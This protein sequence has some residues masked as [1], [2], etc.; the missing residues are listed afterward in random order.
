[1]STSNVTIQ[2]TYELHYA[3]SATWQSDGTKHW[4]VCSCGAEVDTVPH[5]PDR[6]EATETK[7][8]RRTECGF[9]ITP[10]LGHVTHAPYKEWLFDYVKHWNN[11]T[12]CSQKLDEAEHAFGEWTITVQPQVGVAGEKERKCSV[13]GNK[14]TELVAK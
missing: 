6:A 14:E 11:C 10:A 4:H 12:G 9:I 7:P 2:S 3:T 8:V 1:M 13:C 5:T